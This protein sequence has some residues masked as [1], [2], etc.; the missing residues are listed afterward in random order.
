M[1]W[2]LS[3]SSIPSQACFL[4]NQANILEEIAQNVFFVSHNN[5]VLN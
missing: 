5:K 4:L 1:K 3:V 2:E